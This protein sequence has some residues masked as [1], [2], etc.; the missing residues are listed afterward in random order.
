MDIRGKILSGEKTFEEMALKY[1]QDPSA[2]QGAGSLG[3]VKRGNLVTAFESVAFNLSP[4]EISE[5]VK[6]EFGYHII[7]IRR[8]SWRQNKR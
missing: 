2:K 4:G 6:T 1:S 8:G 5:P 7:E 3:F